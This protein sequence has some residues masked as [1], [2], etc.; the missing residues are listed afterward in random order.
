M[1]L[2]YFLQNHPQQPKKEVAEY[3]RSQGFKVPQTFATIA[4]ALGWQRSTN[5]DL[6]IRSEHPDS[7]EGMSGVWD[8]LMLSANQP[9]DEKIT[10]QEIGQWL[11]MTEPYGNQHKELR[12]KFFDYV[13]SQLKEVDEI[14]AQKLLKQ[15]Q[16]PTA[17]QYAKLT[18]QSVGDVLTSL[19]Y[20]YWQKLPGVN[21][22]I[23]A[24]SGCPNKYHIFRD[25]NVRNAGTW[26]QVSYGNEITRWYE[27]LRGL[28]YFNS[29]HC[30]ILE[31]QEH[32]GEIYLLQY[33]RTQDENFADFELNILD[34][35]L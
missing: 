31:F 27:D 33:Y 22:S 5:G 13:L 28:E 12:L 10:P 7:Y 32:N 18:Q 2:D 16:I 4:E 25:L 29:K 30:P 6:I 3:V 17:N 24:D 1:S 14:E 34:T 26:E 11:Q 21:G 19:S 23:V 35:I 8:S 15:T 9:R 20:S